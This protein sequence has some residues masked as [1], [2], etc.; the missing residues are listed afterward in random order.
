[1]CAKHT[2]IYNIIYHWNNKWKKDMWNT[3]SLLMM[4]NIPGKQTTFDW[5]I[6]QLSHNHMKWC[7]NWT[8]SLHSWF[9]LCGTWITE[10]S[11]A[12]QQAFHNYWRQKIC[13]K[14][15]PLTYTIPKKEISEITMVFVKW[16]LQ[17]FRLQIA[18]IF[19]FKLTRLF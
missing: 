17:L 10:W 14:T 15:H 3:I 11:L 1:M 2:P 19:R 5:V 12:L 18:N 13:R 9:T 6:T 7:N 8:S 4:L 16:H